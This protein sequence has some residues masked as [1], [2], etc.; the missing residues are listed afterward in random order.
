MCEKC[1]DTIL[2]K[3]FYS[4]R[5]YMNCLEYIAELIASGQFIMVEQTCPL[6][7]V[8]DKNGCWFRDNIRHK[9]VCNDCGEWFLAWADTYHGRGGFKKEDERFK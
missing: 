6:N 2:R 1:K 5:D 7:A 8:Q 9:I 4:P 3:E